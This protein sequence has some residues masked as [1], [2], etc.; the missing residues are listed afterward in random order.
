MIDLAHVLGLRVVAEGVETWTEMAQLRRLG[1]DEIQGYLLAR[2]G[3]PDTIDRPA[4]N[5][6][7]RTLVPAPADA[8]S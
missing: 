1:C 4:L 5:R 2:P 7:A 6:R 3:S 8:P